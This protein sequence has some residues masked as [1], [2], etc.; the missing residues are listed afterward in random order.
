MGSNPKLIQLREFNDRRRIHGR[1]VQTGPT[2][3]ALYCYIFPA[4]SGARARRSYRLIYCSDVINE[5]TKLPD[6]SSFGSVCMIYA[7]EC[8]LLPNA[9]AKLS[10]HFDCHFPF[11]TFNPKYECDFFFMAIR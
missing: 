11:S 9:E 1:Q 2:P 8:E 7:A 3:M 4:E 5:Q 10:R 6:I